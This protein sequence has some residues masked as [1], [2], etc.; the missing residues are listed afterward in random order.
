M[1]EVVVEEGFDV[2]GEDETCLVSKG[3]TPVL[4][5]LL[6]L[7]CSIR[8]DSTLDSSSVSLIKDGVQS[9]TET[10]SK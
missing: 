4:T 10:V 5:G 6:T 7:Q 8:E 3:Y 2:M 1:C 9:R